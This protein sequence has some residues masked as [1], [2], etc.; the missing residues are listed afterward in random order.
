MNVEKVLDYATIVS[1]AVF[2]AILF[3][4]KELQAFI[5]T[6]L[7]MKNS[8]FKFLFGSIG[9]P[10]IL[11]FIKT[12]R[13]TTAEMNK[14]KLDR[15]EFSFMKKFDLM[16]LSVNDVKESVLDIASSH[17][18]LV[19]IVESDVLGNIK[20]MSSKMENWDE[21]QDKIKKASKEFD[22]EWTSASEKFHIN[23][24][25]KKAA[26]A[27]YFRMRDFTVDVMKMSVDQEC[28]IWEEFVTH[29]R[30]KFVNSIDRAYNDMENF[31]PKEFIDKFVSNNADN[32]GDYVKDIKMSFGN[33][34]ILNDRF[35]K[36]ERHS[37]IFL[38]KSMN[39]LAISFKDSYEILL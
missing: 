15:L 6:E 10:F 34:N 14:L 1:V 19:K 28:I 24:E 27:F 13:K 3:S 32:I 35:L 9:V 17:N 22:E 38:S 2:I 33:T 29:V 25:L 37:I 26:R 36:F 7:G 16:Q 18:S 4:Y 21:S 8:A 11:Q 23:P 31:F 39:T 20:S 5:V 30:E 12:F